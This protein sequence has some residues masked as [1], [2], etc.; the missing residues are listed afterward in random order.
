MDV[1]EGGNDKAN[2]ADNPSES[3]DRSGKSTVTNSQA[4]GSGQ[5][6]IMSSGARNGSG[7]S[8]D[9]SEDTVLELV[10]DDN[11]VHP[12]YTLVNSGLNFSQNTCGSCKF[13]PKEK[14]SSF[15]MQVSK[16]FKILACL[17]RHNHALNMRRLL[18]DMRARRVPWMLIFREI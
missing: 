11:K 18:R 6:I 10:T 16:G 12:A 14:L 15:Y 1:D 13:A 7:P 5:N 2:D 3:R 9:Q 8:Q 17:K 4:S